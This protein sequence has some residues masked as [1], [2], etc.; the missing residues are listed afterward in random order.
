M[1]NLGFSE[2]ESE[3]KMIPEF[4]ERENEKTIPEIPKREK[5][6]E[7]NDSGNSGNGKWK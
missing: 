1:Q 3:K 4:P 5:E 2:T 7:N 6:N